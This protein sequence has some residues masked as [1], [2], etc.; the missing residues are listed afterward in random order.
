M[1]DTKLAILKAMINDALTELMVKTRIDNVFMTD[2]TTTLA[3]KLAE[4]IAAIN[5][6]EKIVDVDAKIEAAKSE[7]NQATKAEI[8]NITAADIGAASKEYVNEQIQLITNTGIPKLMVYPFSI[9]AE[10]EGQTVFEI[11]LDTFDANTDTVFVQSGRTMISPNEDFSVVDNSVVLT[12]GVPV[13]R[14]ITIYVFKNVPI[15][16]DGSVSGSVIMP[17]SLTLDRLS[18]M[19]TAEQVGAVPSEVDWLENV[20][21]FETIG[22]DV[23]DTRFYKFGI[24]SANAPSGWTY[25]SVLKTGNSAIA[26][27]ASIKKSAIA[28]SRFTDEAWSAWDITDDMYLPLTG[29]T[30]SGT[31]GIANGV[32]TF[33]CGTGLLEFGVMTTPNVPADRRR[34]L[35]HAANQSDLASA[36]QIVD[37][38]VGKIYNIFGEHNKPYG[39]YTGNVSATARTIQT[40]GIGSVLALWSSSAIGLVTYGGAI[41]VNVNGAVT[42]LD[43]SKMYLDNGNLYMATD[44]VLVNQNGD[45]VAYQVL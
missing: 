14:V 12:E 30:L 19:P 24:P 5:V 3:T 4:I 2:K 7:V 34:S 37:D 25:F 23:T 6:R 15:G 17:G 11:P 28:T 10:T 13:E 35:L 1:A 22:T 33:G 39:I 27:G 8:D 18:A 21:V 45:S 29:G 41:L 36:F 9:V 20:D 32:G 38:S 31:L 43:R 44:S 16:E 40:G 26:F 42:F